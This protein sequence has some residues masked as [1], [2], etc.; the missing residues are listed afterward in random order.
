MANEPYRDTSVTAERSKGQISTALRGVGAR[1]LQLEEEWDENGR[2][3]SCVVRFMY[4]TEKGSMMRVR[5]QAKPLDPEKGARGGWK[6]SPEQ[7]ERQAW[8]GL[9]WYIESLAKAAAFGFVRFEEVFL[10][11]FEDAKGRTIGESLV[12]QI[13][14]G[15]LELPRGAS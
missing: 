9:A 7:R 10:A 5:F 6:T 12:P 11:Y 4:P 15:R 14:Q 13:E 1:G 2:V 8:R 3:T